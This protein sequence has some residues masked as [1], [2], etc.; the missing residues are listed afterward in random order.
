MTIRTGY[1]V[2]GLGYLLSSSTRPVA[3]AVVASF[4]LVICVPETRG[5][6]IGSRVVAELAGEVPVV[7]AAPYGRVVAVGP[8][9]TGN[10]EMC[11]VYP[12]RHFSSPVYRGG[13]SNPCGIVALAARRD[14]Y[15]VTLPDTCVGRVAV[16]ALG[17]AAACVMVYCSN[18]L[19]RT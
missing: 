10:S 13:A 8:V 19:G 1:V 18:R 3:L 12:A 11:L 15:I 9:G 4:R 5:S 6:V 14:S 7:P 17:I 16:V 2:V